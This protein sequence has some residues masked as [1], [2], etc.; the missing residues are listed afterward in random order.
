MLQTPS[1]LAPPVSVVSE[2]A[3][4]HYCDSNALVATTTSMLTY[5]IEAELQAAK[6]ILPSYNTTCCSTKQDVHTV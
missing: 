2:L 4:T 5:L 6:D 1:C 3:T